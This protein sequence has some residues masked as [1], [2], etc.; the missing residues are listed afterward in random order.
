MRIEKGKEKG[1]G[2]KK[3]VFTPAQGAAVSNEKSLFTHRFNRW[4][5]PQKD[6]DF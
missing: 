4:R 1:N 6:C 3:D 5:W 2:K